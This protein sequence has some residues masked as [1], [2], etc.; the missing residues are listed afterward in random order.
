M[1]HGTQHFDS[2]SAVRSKELAQAKA[3]GSE[4]DIG[5]KSSDVQLGY[6]PTPRYH[7]AHA[8]LKRLA[9]AAGEAS[10][11]VWHIDAVYTGES[12]ERTDADHAEVAAELYATLYVGRLTD[13]GSDRF[14]RAAMPYIRAGF[15]A[16]A[17]HC[18]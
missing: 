9:Y 13:D 5:G 7:G 10:Y 4:L 14:A 18:N 2:A 3:N 6:L 8:L 11:D 16:R 17:Q 12:W 1:A 15:E